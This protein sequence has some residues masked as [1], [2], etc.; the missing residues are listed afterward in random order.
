MKKQE[1]KDRLVQSNE[2]N[3]KFKFTNLSIDDFN[4]T[5]TEWNEELGVEEDF[6]IWETVQIDEIQIHRDQIEKLLESDIAD[7]ET[8]CWSG[9]VI[10]SDGEKVSR[11]AFGGE[12][13][14]DGT[15]EMGNI[16]I[17]IADLLLADEIEEY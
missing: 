4:W 1:I 14:T 16:C 9:T 5:G 6:D 11:P 12:S 2:E 8:S 7:T 17:R 10:E 3:F 15:P 13:N